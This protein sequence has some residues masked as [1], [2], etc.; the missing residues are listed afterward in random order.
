M[1]QLKIRRPAQV[2]KGAILVVVM[3]LLIDYLIAHSS[4]FRALGR[5]KLEYL[6][7]VAL[8]SGFTLL[9]A[10]IRFRLFLTQISHRIP[11]YT[12]LKYYI[13]GRFLNR[14]LPFGGSVYRAIM[15]KKTDGVSYKKYVASNLAFDWLNMVYSTL[16]GVIVIAV[17][18]PSLRIGFIP[19]LPF[20]SA[21]LVLLILASP[22]A[23]AGIALINRLVSAPSVRK[24]M[25]DTEEI[26][27]TVTNVLKNRAVFT[28]SS[29]IITLIL[30]STL[31]SYH[32]LF[33]SI[34]IDTDFAVLLIY[35]IVLRFVRVIRITPANL[36][37]REFLLGFL[38]FS[39]GTGTAEGVMVSLLMRLV[40][41][42]VQGGLSIGIFSGERAYRLINADKSSE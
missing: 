11:F 5:I 13:Y 40:T 37:I 3:V 12:V 21:A 22:I 30:A 36:G 18:D 35:L 39:L 32:L 20:F 33:K 16:L 34:G 19:L 28:G 25:E 10:S 24:R 17:Y 26:V 4:E 8:L 15:L 6:L 42:L 2:I 29:A 14:F 27:E 38:T 9:L 1:P 31:I 41:L 23:K 7:P